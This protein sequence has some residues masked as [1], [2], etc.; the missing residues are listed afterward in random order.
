MLFEYLKTYKAQIFNRG[1]SAKVF[2]E[3]H[4]KN[5]AICVI[6]NSEPYVA[7]LPHELYLELVEKV[8]RTNSYSKEDKCVIQSGPDTKRIERGIGL[9]E[10]SEIHLC[11]RESSG[12]CPGEKGEGNVGIK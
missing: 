6:K 3:A 11:D 1:Q 9:S 5:A 10:H 8:R 7:I 4:E 12:I 2:K